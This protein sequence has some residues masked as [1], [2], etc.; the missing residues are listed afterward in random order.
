MI[1]VLE[2]KTNGAEKDEAWAWKRTDSAQGIASKKV[3][4]GP[5]ELQSYEESGG[6]QPV[7]SKL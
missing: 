7:R 3:E 1:N 5:Q 6:S 2:G 4:E